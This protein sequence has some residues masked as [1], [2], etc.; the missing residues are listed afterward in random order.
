MQKSQVR[1]F[2]SASTA[3][4]K[5]YNFVTSEK[6]DT[7]VTHTIF[8]NQKCI[9]IQLSQLNGVSETRQL[10]K[11]RAK[12]LRS[13]QKEFSRLQVT[14]L[15]IFSISMSRYLLA[16]EPITYSANDNF[17]WLYHNFI[18]FPTIFNVTERLL[19]FSCH[20][21]KTSPSNMLFFAVAVFYELLYLVLQFVVTTLESWYLTLFPKKMKSLAGEI[22]LVSNTYCIGLPAPCLG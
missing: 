10:R 17:K 8:L 22:I 7:R 3:C 19:W 6:L 21:D 18:Y 12:C 15:T 9:T 2:Q 11:Q 4:G 5:L 16:T 20:R 13:T 14:K 1:I